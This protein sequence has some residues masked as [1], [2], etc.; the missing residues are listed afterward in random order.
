MK[1]IKFLCVVLTVLSVCISAHAYAPIS[2]IS[3]QHNSFTGAGTDAC[4]VY[5]SGKASSTDS[6]AISSNNPNAVVSSSKVYITRGYQSGGF[7][8]S[9]A[10]VS[11]TQNAIIKATFGGKSVTYGITLNAV[12]TASSADT[13]SAITCQSSS[14]TSQ[15]TDSCSVRLTAAATANDTVKL[16]SSDSNVVPTPSVTIAK[17]SSTAAFSINVAAVTTQQTAT[18]S[19]TL[20]SS[21]VRSSLNLYPPT[22]TIQHKVTLSW[23]APAPNG[24]AIAGYHVYRS[25]GSNTAKF[26]EISAQSTTTYIDTNVTSG[27]AYTY[28]IRSVDANGVESSNS[29]STVVTIPTP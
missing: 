24:D 13:L 15:G 20:G 29:N 18:I 14:F 26:G 12:A 21:V 19:A 17:G 2:K 11:T 28:V 16:T 22:A 7:S 23:S 8:I 5:M 10:A 9:I 4:S 1:I 6:V 3:C 27:S 25:A